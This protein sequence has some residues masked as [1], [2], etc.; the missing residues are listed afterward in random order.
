MLTE[1][2]P[3]LQFEEVPWVP[4]VLYV[5]LVDQLNAQG[6]GWEQGKGRWFKG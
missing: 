5:V 3:L 2:G 1:F 6:T 4:V